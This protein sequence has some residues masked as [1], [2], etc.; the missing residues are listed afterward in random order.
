MKRV[1][2]L[3]ALASAWLC[4][5]AAADGPAPIPPLSAADVVALVGGTQLAAAADGGYLETLLAFRSADGAPRFRD[6]SWEGDTVF[7]RPRQVNFPTLTHQ[8]KVAGATVVLLQFGQMESLAGVAGRPDF[9]TAAASRVKEVRSVVPRVVLV[10]PPPFAVGGPLDAVAVTARNR[11]LA[12]YVE[13]IRQLGQREQIPVVDVFAALVPSA[14]TPGL[15]V[16]GVQ[17][18]DRG[19]RQMAQS[20][21]SG[22]GA[23]S[24]PDWPALEPV[25][26]AVVAKNQL[27]FRY[28]RPTNWAFLAGD[29]TEQPSSRDH[30][31]R[32]IRWFPKEMEEYVPLIHAADDR[33]SQQVRQVQQ[34][35][36][37]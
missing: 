12:V 26:Q 16:D 13:A 30:R 21:A 11:D 23:V 14:G 6:L 32:T 24:S 9:E 17:L 25:R 18:S 27:W 22:W 31:D 8:L 20:V 34:E 36:A 4:L 19:Q 3:L 10:T 33:I 5:A 28:W 29:R 2:E 37:R 15:T 35:A 1:R 7:A